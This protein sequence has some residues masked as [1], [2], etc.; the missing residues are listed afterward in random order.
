M[1]YQL[2]YPIHPSILQV[3]RKG[4]KNNTDLCLPDDWFQHEPAYKLLRD[5]CKKPRIYDTKQGRWKDAEPL[6]YILASMD[7]LVTISTTRLKWTMDSLGLTV[8]WIM[9]T[10]MTGIT[11]H[12]QIGNRVVLEP[13][14]ELFSG[15]IGLCECIQPSHFILAYQLSV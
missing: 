9:H 15:F 7:V 10:S 12:G 3:Q 13:Y 2:K 8:P 11:E 4:T 14:D 5:A 6:I 1:A